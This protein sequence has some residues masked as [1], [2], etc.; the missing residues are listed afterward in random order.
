MVL[1]AQPYGNYYDRMLSWIVIIANNN[2][3][4]TSSV[5]ICSSC[6]DVVRSSWTSCERVIIYFFTT[7]WTIV[8]LWWV[9]LMLTIQLYFCMIGPTITSYSKHGY[10]YY[11]IIIQ[12]LTQYRF[13][14]LFFHSQ[15]TQIQIIHVNV[16]IRAYVHHP[17]DASV[18]QHTLVKNVRFMHSRSSSK[19]FGLLWMLTKLTSI[20]NQPKPTIT[21]SPSIFVCY[22]IPHFY[23]LYFTYKHKKLM[24]LLAR[25]ILCFKLRKLCLERKDMYLLPLIT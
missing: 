24:E 8:D 16:T 6:S 5:T 12:G 9:E 14:S 7:A 11:K 22:K 17:I 4:L 10:L 15:Y 20:S 13:L 2:K 3:H 19:P 18:L 25:F 23:L 1:L 21:G